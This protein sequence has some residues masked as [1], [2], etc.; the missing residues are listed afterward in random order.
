MAKCGTSA[1][2]PGSAVE[3]VT[4]TVGTAG[5]IDHGKTQLIHLL[6]GCITDRLPEEKARGM[7]IDLGFATC[8][9]PN[10]KRVGIVDVP[11]HERFI[12]NMVAGAAG[13]DAVLLVVAAD[14]GVM[15]QTIEHFHIVRMLGVGSGMV[16]VTKTDL[17]AP[18][19][20]AEVQ[21]EVENLVAG[22]FMEGCAIVPVS[23]KTGEGFDGFYDAFV[24]MVD[25]T[26]ERDATGGFRLHVE[27]SFVLKGL[28]VIISGIPQ[29]GM[30]RVGDQVEL[31]PAGKKK[32]VRGIQV[33]GQDAQEGRAGEC[34][35]LRLSDTSRD[36]VKR[37][38]VVASIGYFEPARFVNARFHYLP[39]AG[40]P[41]KPR[42]AVRF[43]IGTTDMPGHVVLPDLAPLSPGSECY[44][45][46]QLKDAVVAAP[47]DFYVVRLLSPETTIGGG[48]V[49]APDH[50]RMR[51]SRGNW[52]DACREHEEAFKEPS[53]AL[54]HVLEHA[55]GAP[56]RVAELAR[57][58]FL[59]VAAVAEHLTAMVSAG[60][61]VHLAG[62]RYVHAG[63][64]DL[65]KDEIVRVLGE[66]HDVKPLATGFEKKEVYP[67]LT[68]EKPL[69]ESALAD[70]VDADTIVESTVGL[71][72][73]SRAPSLSEGQRALATKIEGLFKDGGFA[74]M[75]PDQVPDTV[76]AP[77]AVVRPVMEF[78]VQ[79]GTL[80]KMDDKILLHEEM[81]E[82]SK[83]LIVAFLDANAELESGAFKD[84]LGTTRK[85]S[86]PILEYWDS[87]GLTKRVG[88]TRTLRSV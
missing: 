82:D 37:G 58:S 62:D 57:M 38:M 85:Y 23:S 71:S 80:V 5:H 77:E 47:S 16:A 35:A 66:M 13:I 83:R 19:R 59:S 34:V 51:R 3:T 53:S 28:G 72:L 86:I 52:V 24:A 39:Q 17:V 8:E 4:L 81:V 29:S 50:M 79:V 75:R 65:A 36:E 1:P 12:H 63:G 46:I 15:P 40:R 11:G 20:V 43:H 26:A 21:Q 44:V 48:Y 76:G 33:Y 70:L 69:I 32:K 22:S 14:D 74:T 30:V 64:R 25:R 67:R 9:L 18:G 68:A 31:L 6:T 84:M 7:T 73:A 49:V 10:N 87:Q 42:T 55:G 27:R 56:L 41:L 88:N 54:L 45:Q 2:T 61:V 60:S 78:L